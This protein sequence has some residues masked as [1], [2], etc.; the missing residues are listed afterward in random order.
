MTTI[1]LR[2]DAFLRVARAHGHTTYETQA[3]AANV[4]VGTL[5]R[6]RNGLPVSSRTVAAILDAYNGRFDDLFSTGATASAQQHV[7]IAA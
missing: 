5:W 6:A 4:G 1:W 3:A 7:R 2:T